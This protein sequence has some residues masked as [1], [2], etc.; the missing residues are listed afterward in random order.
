MSNRYGACESN[1][2]LHTLLSF[3]WRSM[4]RNLLPQWDRLK[5][6]LR[7]K[8]LYSWM[9]N[10][11]LRICYKFVYSKLHVGSI[12]FST[13]WRNGWFL[14]HF[15]VV[16][17]RN[18]LVS[19]LN[20]SKKRLWSDLMA[21]VHL[22]V[23]RHFQS[24]ATPYCIFPTC[25]WVISMIVFWVLNWIRL[26]ICSDRIDDSKKVHHWL[27]HLDIWNALVKSSSITDIGLFT[28]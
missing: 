19:I 26:I 9:L 15:C 6:D 2:A 18:N 25:F 21:C 16:G 28:W 14:F 17:I 8:L 1:S 12:G 5:F 24:S 10:K 3:C 27:L 11:N 7:R 22:S 4:G 13:L 23:S 20:K